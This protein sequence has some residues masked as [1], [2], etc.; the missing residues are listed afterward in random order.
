[1]KK[2]KVPKK[3][4]IFSFMYIEQYYDLQDKMGKIVNLIFFYHHIYFNKVIKEMSNS[5]F[6]V[7]SIT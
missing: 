2:K 1:M 5:T 6:L 4:L 3:H 7:A